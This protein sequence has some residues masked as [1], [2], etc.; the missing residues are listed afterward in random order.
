MDNQLD[1]DGTP[2]ESE[3]RARRIVRTART[4][5]LGVLFVAASTLIL[6]FQLLPSTQVNL[7]A[8]EVA[9][10]DILSPIR[11][12]YISD[13]ETEILREAAI[14]AV[15]DVYDAPDARVGRQ[16]VL[17]ARQIMEFV[18][19]VRHDTLSSP[20]QQSEALAAVTDLDLDSEN[21]RLMLTMTDGQLDSV[22]DEIT[23]VL[24][25]SL[26]GEV[27]EGRLDEVQEELPLRISVDLPED[28]GLLVID[29]VEDLML[30]NSLY[31]EE[32]TEQ[33]REAARETVEPVEHTFAP[34][35]VVVR[36]GDIV[37]DSDIE[38]LQHLG[39]LQATIGWREI[40]SRLIAV[41]VGTVILLLYLDRFYREVLDSFRTQV[42]ASGMFVLFLF[43]ARL[44]VPEGLIFPFL[45]PAA[46][47]SL[48]LT[49]LFSADV[50][51]VN[52]VVL[53]GLTGL[54]ANQSLELATFITV[55]GIT[56]AVS[57]RRAERL[58]RFF[59]AGVFVSLSQV[60][61]ILVFRLA[62]SGTDTR[63]LLELTA[64]ATINGLISAGVALAGL[65]IIGPLFRLTTPLTLIEL[66]RPDHK[67]LLR[68]QREAPGTFQHSLQVRNLAEAASAA[69]GANSVLVRVGTLYHDI[70]KVLRPSF[71]IE[72]RVKGGSNPHDT[73][74]PLSSA[75][76]IIRH[77]TDGLELA[78][79][80][81]L[82][83]QIRDFIPEHHGTAPVSFF[84]Q[85]AVDQAD[86]DKSKVDESAFRYG[87]PRPQSRETAIL[88][89][90]DASESA[91]RANQPQ[92]EE[93]ID[94]IVGKII[95]QRMDWGELNESGLT[96]T[97]LQTIRRTFVSSLKGIYHPRIR[98][99]GDKVP[100]PQ[101]EQTADP[102][103]D[104]P[105]SG[106]SINQESD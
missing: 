92:S 104:T 11:R 98:Y 1:P 100:E 21:T 63:G 52:I 91:V 13:I 97:D 69:I 49:A 43:G 57:L 27:R 8:G 87:G 2:A 30:P 3:Q 45:F 73:L 40:T 77:T 72:N 96:L 83:K 14:S 25:D 74:D 7:Q 39:L 5:V 4:V 66:E 76:I 47:L 59:L 6:I 15:P 41:L 50:A 10:E 37:T 70:G 90:S 88:M 61:V 12:T 84:Y 65:F 31:N 81:R 78:R 28:H 55:G 29:V 102:T 94:E 106:I 35:E 89:L 62:D 101:E 33:A 64:V 51:I 95:Q 67:L 103:A 17:Y 80:Y 38:A 99:P 42:L 24:A 26:S 19:T 22:A 56:A 53:A 20:T 79:K 32:L 71:F 58:D 44:M 23:S 48:L 60:A 93:E 34:D 16:Q 9:P 54:I 18:Q 105:P 36:G 75:D 85:K 82:P 46:A 68:L 86:G